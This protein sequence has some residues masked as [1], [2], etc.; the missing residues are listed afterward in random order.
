MRAPEQ[1]GKR[2]LPTDEVY[3][4]TVRPGLRPITCGGET[5]DGRR[6]ADTIVYADLVG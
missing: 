5:T 1:A 6:P 3:G 4:N 2:R